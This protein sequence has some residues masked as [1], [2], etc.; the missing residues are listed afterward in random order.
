[1]QYTPKYGIC[2]LAVTLVLLGFCP[3]IAADAESKWSYSGKTGPEHWGELS[4][5]FEMCTDGKNQSP[6]DLTAAVDTEQPELVFRYQGT[7]LRE[8]NNGHTIM[9]PVE[10][11]SYLE[12]PDWGKRYQLVQAHF[13]SPSEHT[14]DGEHFAMEIHLVHQ[15]EDGG[16]AVVGILMNEGEENTMLHDVWAFMPDQVGAET[17]APVRVFNAGVLR[18]TR[19]YFSYNGS[20]T[21]PPCSEGIRWMVLQEHTTAS[22]EQIA[23]FQQRVGT[24]TNRP[25]QPVNA[26]NILY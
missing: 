12:I 15:G 14:I 13:H 4:A 23:R 10:T 18:P 22:A 2:R 26:R 19:N 6:I 21:T 11:G 24:I 8:I 17:Q 25:V 9:L 5:E 3:A 16:L 7:P 20:L 1:M